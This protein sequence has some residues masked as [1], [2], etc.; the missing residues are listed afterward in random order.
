MAGT[1]TALG[2]AGGGWSSRPMFIYQ[3][4]PVAN[5][6]PPTASFTV[7]CTL[8]NCSFNGSASSDSDGM[9][10]NYAWDFGD[11]TS[12]SGASATTSHTYGA[13]GPRTVRLTVTDNHLPTGTTTRTA[14]P[15]NTQT[16]VAFV[17]ASSTSGNR[18]SHTVTIPGSVQPGDLLVL[19]FVANSTTPTYT[20]P[21]GWTQIE[22][23]SGDTTA[24]RAYTKIAT[25]GDAGASV[26]VTSSAYAKDVTSVVAY[27]GVDLGTPLTDSASELQTSSTAAHSTPTVNAPDGQQWLVS[28]WADKSSATT[29]WALPGGVT[30]RSTAA[31]TGSGHVSAV[32]GDSGQVPS[33]AQGGLVATANSAGSSAVTFSLLVNPN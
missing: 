3:G 32:L 27:R 7:S 33:G 21:A 18:L 4:P 14:N 8:L 6:V 16:P 29:S 30:Q 19:F 24:G 1:A 22:T 31:G 25:G 17:G 20:G 23:Q 26:A 12:A 15:T 10:T 13:P 9:I 2:L 28:Y 5:P 11:G